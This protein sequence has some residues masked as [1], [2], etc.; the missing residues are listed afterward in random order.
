MYFKKPTTGKK[1]E[2]ERSL[3][4]QQIKNKLFN[5]M[6]MIE[7]AEKKLLTTIKGEYQMRS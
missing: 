5:E 3:T 2:A 6:V 7:H 1:S 4:Y